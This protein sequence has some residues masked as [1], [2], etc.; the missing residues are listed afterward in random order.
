MADSLTRDEASELNRLCADGKLYEVEAWIRSGRSLVVPPELRTKPLAVAISTGFHSLVELLLRHEPS[1]EAK[2]DSL[3]LALFENRQAL[4]ELALAHGAA[5]TAVPLLDVLTTGNRS[6]VTSFLERGADPITGFPFAHAFHDFPA[7]TTLGSY[8]ECRKMRPEL[9]AALQEQADMALRQFCQE[10][11]L[12]WVSLLMWVGADPRSRGPALDDADEAED[13]NRQTTA[14]EEACFSGK[15]EILKRLKPSAAD[16]LGTLLQQAAVYADCEMLSFLLDLGANPN[17]KADGGS[18]ALE[19]CIKY[20]GAEDSALA[21][22]RR[23]VGYYHPSRQVSKGRE[24]LKLLLEHGARWTPEMSTLNRT[25][26]ILYAMEPTITVQLVDQLRKNVDGDDK[27]RELLRVP[28]MRERVKACERE[29]RPA[30]GP[31]EAKRNVKKAEASNKPAPW[32]LRFDREQ[33][34]EDV[35]SAP[36]EQVAKKHGISGVAIAKVCRRLKIPKPPRGYWAKKAAGRRVSGRPKL[37]ALEGPK[38][39]GRRATD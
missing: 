32:M 21:R 10:A 39:G 4:V 23:G 30:E 13:P 7:K 36:A 29:V 5:I 31:L 19:N 18:T 15:P 38:Q 9:A 26:R 24:G 2:D 11:N 12:K 8:L 6:L 16:D 37:P 27:V 17:D 35:W 22:Y 3:R 1:Q 28:R 33:L 20:T 34:Y 25:R 14:L